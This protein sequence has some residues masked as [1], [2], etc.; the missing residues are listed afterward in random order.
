MNTI[1]NRHGTEGV[2]EVIKLVYD[3]IGTEQLD[4]DTDEQMEEL[5]RTYLQ[6]KAEGGL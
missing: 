4:D 6:K 2:Y 3:S 5:L 1:Y